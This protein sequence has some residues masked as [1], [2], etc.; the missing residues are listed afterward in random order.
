MANTPLRNAFVLASLALVAACGRPLDPADTLLCRLDR[1]ELVDPLTHARTYR[2]V[3]D[4]EGRPLEVPLGISGLAR[5]RV[6]AYGALAGFADGKRLYPMI[7]G[8]LPPG[9]SRPSDWYYRSDPTGMTILEI[10]RAKRPHVTVAVHFNTSTP[11]TLVGR[12][13]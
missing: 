6:L 5:G 4:S 9:E 12:C 3:R 2:P 10:P 11:A 8:E 13:R 1:Y 7:A